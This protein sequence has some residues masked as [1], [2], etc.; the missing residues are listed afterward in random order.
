MFITRS[1]QLACPL[2]DISG[3][4]PARC[5]LYPRKRTF[6]SAKQMSALGQKRTFSGLGAMGHFV[7]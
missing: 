5:T 6:G 2:W 7:P 3:H 4:L 1:G